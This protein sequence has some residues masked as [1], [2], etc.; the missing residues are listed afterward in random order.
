[1]IE[2]HVSPDIYT[3]QELA[4]LDSAFKQAVSELEIDSDPE[5]ESV[6]A[7]ILHSFLC[8]VRER[9]VLVRTGRNLYAAIWSS[10][11]GA[12]KIRG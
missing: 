11:G 1:M 12:R 8:G 5:R 7:A 6:A 4:L 9:E 10:P 3:P 2:Y